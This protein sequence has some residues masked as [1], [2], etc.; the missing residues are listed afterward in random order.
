MLFFII[1]KLQ[2]KTIDRQGRVTTNQYDAIRELLQTTDPLGRTTK[3]TWCTC[4]GLSTLTDANNNVTTW[5]LDE[6]G[7]VTSKTYA[8]SSAISYTYETHTSRLHTMTDA[9]G[10]VATYAYNADNTLSGTTY[11]PGSGV[12]STPNVS[13]SYD[14]VY[15]RVTGMTDGTGT[16]SYSYNGVYTSG[17]PITGG[18]RLAS[19]SVPIA[20]SSAAITCGYDALG[21]VTERDV[22]HSSTDANNVSTTFD[23]LGRVTGVTNALGAFTY[24]Y[25]DTTSRLSSVTYPTGTGGTGHSMI[26]DYSYYGNTGD[27]RLE[28]IQNLKYTTQLSQFDYTYN[29]VGTIATWT[30][31]ADS[32]TAIVNTLSYDGADQLANAVQS[33]GGSAS[34]AYHY[35]PA[36]NRLAEVTGS[37]TTAGQFNTLNQLTGLSS[38]TTSQTVAGHASAAITSA[39]INALSATI[40]SSTNFT[41]NV[42]LPSGTNVVSVVAQ[43]TSSTGSITT[44]RYQIVLSGTAPT[45]L[46]YDANGNVLTDEN[47]YSYTW[48]AL[49]RMTKITY[50]GGATSNFAYDG[51]SRRIS[52]I[53]KNSGGTVTSTKNYLWIGSEIA[54]ERNASNTVT[55][56]F[57]P[58]GEQ[59]SGTNYYYT[60]DH[61]GSIRE[62][63]S[64]S[65]SIV[66]RYSYDPYGRTTLVSGTN[67]AT[68][69]YV[70]DYT[71]QTSGLNLTLFRA[72]DLNAGRWLSRDPIGEN[73]GVNLYEYVDSSPIDNLDPSGLRTETRLVPLYKT[74]ATKDYTTFYDLTEGGGCYRHFFNHHWEWLVQVYRIQQREAVQDLADDAEFLS[75][76]SLGGAVVSAAYGLEPIAGGLEGL[77]QFMDGAAGA[78][79]YTPW[80]DVGTTS[81]MIPGTLRRTTTTR[82]QKI[83]NCPCGTS[84]YGPIP[85][86]PPWS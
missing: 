54:E 41:A 26:T 68:F 52:I 17:S 77:S 15:N 49:N 43:P 37:G 5:G 81:E 22:D 50:S 83:S 34:N 64:S 20:S 65:G 7:R 23:S 14:T 33:G 11:S 69:Q 25:V 39:T 28:E 3:Y 6:Q 85:P 29:A 36:G 59:Q 71:H 38:S 84:N 4:G 46:T 61:L 19:V 12:A 31:Q 80:V 57:F 10:S 40:S 53:E 32:S 44:K 47:G 60:R 27:Q 79:R 13:F 35:D 21:R 74:T 55:K 45:S 2:V 18:G 30:T 72:Y 76:A 66:A 78:W 63:C 62:M 75:H 70:G 51:L 8:D 16:T 9:R 86:N 1:Y 48:D 56:R 42:P 82:T 58:Q 67:I 24:A 73:G